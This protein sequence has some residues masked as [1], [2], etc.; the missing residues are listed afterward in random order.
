[1]GSVKEVIQD[2]DS[3]K[4]LSPA[5]EN[6]DDSEDWDWDEYIS[7]LEIWIREKREEFEKKGESPLQTRINLI[8][9]S[10]KNNY[11]SIMGYP[12]QRNLGKRDQPKNVLVDRIKLSMWNGIQKPYDQP[13]F[14]PLNLQPAKPMHCNC[15]KRRDEVYKT[16]FENIK[17]R[18]KIQGPLGGEIREI[19]GLKTKGWAYNTDY[20][21]EQSIE[22]FLNPPRPKNGE[23]KRHSLIIIRNKKGEVKLKSWYSPDDGISEVWAKGYFNTPGTCR[24]CGGILRNKKQGQIY[25]KTCKPMINQFRQKERNFK[26]IIVKSKSG[27]T[28]YNSYD[29]VKYLKRVYFGFDK[30][31]NGKNFD[32][33]K[34]EGSWPDNRKIV[35]GVDEKLDFCLICLEENFGNCDLNVSDCEFIQKKSL[36]L[37]CDECGTRLIS[38]T[39]QLED[40]SIKEIESKNPTYNT[41]YKYAHPLVSNQ[42]KLNDGIKQYNLDIYDNIGKIGSNEVLCPKCGLIQTEQGYRSYSSKPN[43]DYKGIS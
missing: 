1:M 13:H 40:P 3:S 29:F 30:K 7:D 23:Y 26:K 5:M 22:K 2:S 6:N 19:E 36:N 41:K 37:Y 11:R 24:N 9:G 12:L 16:R 4:S 21:N 33:F 32:W 14:Y 27:T 39:L 34:S 8:G 43:L 10:P 28:P 25:C 20:F 42:T 38:S 17:K 18:V 31:T 15:I 35:S